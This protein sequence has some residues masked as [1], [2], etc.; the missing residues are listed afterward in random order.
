ME[1]CFT[2]L[3]DRSRRPRASTGTMSASDAAS[4]ALTKVISESA[5]RHSWVCLSAKRMAESSSLRSFCVSV[6][7][8]VSVTA[9]SAA[10]A[11]SEILGSV[12]WQ[13][14]ISRGMTA[15]TA[16]ETW[17]R[18]S[19]SFWR[20]ARPLS[21]ASAAARSLRELSP[22]AD[23]AAA[24]IGATSSGVAA[25]TS[26]VIK[27]SVIWRAAAGPSL[28]RSSGS[29]RGRTKATAS[30]PSDSTKCVTAVSAAFISA[31]F[32]LLPSS[33]D[34]ASPMPNLVRAGAPISRTAPARP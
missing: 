28:P 26:A 29:R 21:T 4:S 9:S 16:R 31:L 12:S 34:S 24:T 5:S 14:S 13:E 19:G 20:R 30:Y 17:A 10:C 1:A 7:S 8:I 18:S 15:G 2:T 25:A 22:S 33:S 23:T 3:E 11:V 6:W 32:G 27:R